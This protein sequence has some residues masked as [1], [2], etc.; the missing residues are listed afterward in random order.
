MAKATQTVKT[1]TIKSKSTSPSGNKIKC[2]ICHGTGYQ[3]KP[4]KKKK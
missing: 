1:V 4:T 3:T 2:N